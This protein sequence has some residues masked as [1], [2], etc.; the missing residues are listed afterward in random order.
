MIAYYWYIIKLTCQGQTGPSKSIIHRTTPLN[1]SKHLSLLYHQ[2][3]PARDIR[4]PNRRPHFFRSPEGNV[5]CPAC[6]HSLQNFSH[7]IQEVA[8]LEPAC[9]PAAASSSTTLPPPGVSSNPRAIIC[10]AGVCTP[11]AV[12]SPSGFLGS[13]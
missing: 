13:P 11:S 5:T 9:P 2:I 3:P 8:F 10:F 1:Y 12:R 7:S 4:L 6:R